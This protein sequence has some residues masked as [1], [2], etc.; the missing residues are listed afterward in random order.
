MNVKKED[1][2]LG[3]GFPGDFGPTLTSALKLVIGCS[4]CRGLDWRS[5][6]GGKWGPSRGAF[7]GLLVGRSDVENT[8]RRACTP[9]AVHPNLVHLA[10]LLVEQG[11]SEPVGESVD[12][13]GQ[14]EIL[15]KRRTGLALEFVQESLKICDDWVVQAAQMLVDPHRQ[16]FELRQIDRTYDLAAAA[17]L[18]GNRREA[19]RGEFR[20]S[21]GLSSTWI[22][23]RYFICRPLS[24]ILTAPV[25]LRRML[26]SGLEVQPGRADGGRQE[27]TVCREELR[28]HLADVVPDKSS[29]DTLD[30]QYQVEI[31]VSGKFRPKVPG[32]VSIGFQEFGDPVG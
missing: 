19:A 25:H 4:V 1:A 26:H 11:D 20:D 27:L 15:V 28:E 7:Q 2:I 5:P 14:A 10:F 22:W 9:R 3:G 24:L 12:D 17:V 18:G 29:V 13:L 30:G 23:R 21:K 16:F 31:L 32:Q 6:P 8:R